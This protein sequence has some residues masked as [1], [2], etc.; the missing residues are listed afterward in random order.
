MVSIAGDLEKKKLQTNVPALGRFY[1][2][3]QSK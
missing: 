1:R 3:S 2:R